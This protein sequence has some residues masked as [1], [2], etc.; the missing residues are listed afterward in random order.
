MC[1]AH[2]ANATKRRVMAAFRLSPANCF[3][4]FR[5]DQN[6]TTA[7]EFA[8]V[9][10]PFFALM[11]AI[12]ETAMAFFFNQILETATADSARLIMTGQVKAQNMTQQQ[13][14]NQ[15]CSRLPPLFDCASNV[16]IDV[17]VAANFAAADVDKL[18]E[19]DLSKAPKWNPG[20]G[21]DIVVVRVA[22]PMKVWTNF[23]GAS[24]A[25]TSDGKLILMAT[26]SFRNEPFL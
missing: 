19:S 1:I 9:A 7:I 3:R 17:D 23:L 20:V 26:S 25:E 24:M 12:V 21:G 4:R 15:V 10:V 22:Y 13:F 14:K 18:Q 2:R 16:V 5:R 6:G 11:F 8:F